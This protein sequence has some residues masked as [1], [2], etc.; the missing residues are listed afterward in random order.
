MSIKREVKR[1]K[2]NKKNMLYLSVIALILL[3]TI[4]TAYYLTRVNDQATF[5]VSGEPSVYLISFLTNESISTNSS[6]KTYSTEIILKSTG[7]NTGVFYINESKLLT[8]LECTNWEN[9]CLLNISKDNVGLPANST[10]SLTDG[11][12]K[13]T[14]NLTCMKN[15]CN[16][17][18][19][20]AI[21]YIPN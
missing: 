10:I 1:P 6:D 19:N 13:L 16:Q 12:N 20:L 5:T 21:N 4:G 15:S 2:T 3:A 18:I 14:L 9:D 11:Q 7:D 17:N 8:D